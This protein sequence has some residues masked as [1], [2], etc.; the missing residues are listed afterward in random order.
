MT[1]KDHFSGHA[2]E[3]AR[4]RPTYPPEL[5]A[6]LASLAPGRELAWDC[7]T[8]NGQ[9][10]VGLAAHFERVH[11]TDASAA[12]IE[13]AAPHERVT[14]AVAPAERSGLPNAAADLVSIAQALHWVPLDA[15]YAEALR[16][17]KPGGVL[18]A[19]GYSLAHV[20][21]EIDAPIRHFYDETVGPYWPPERAH[22]DQEF[23]TLP[24]P[25]PEI[26]TPPFTMR[27]LWSLDDLIGYIGTWSA[28]QKFTEARR[29]NP[30]PALRRDLE[31]VWGDPR[32]HRPVVWPL[33]LRVGATPRAAP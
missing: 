12:Q 17:L 11:A 18:A 24:F 23:R 10:A 31:S 8:G 13:Q 7:A 15:F 25:L 29:Y 2:A 20:T 33:H 14:Y 28:T 4:F 16:V 21:P 5:F 19:W 32:A 1:F 9:S 22:V 30:L 26:A 3:Y 6:Y 27:I